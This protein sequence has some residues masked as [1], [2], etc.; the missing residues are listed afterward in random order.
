MATGGFRCDSSVQGSGRRR[1][2]FTQS[3]TGRNRISGNEGFTRAESFTDA[4]TATATCQ[5][6][7]TITESRSRVVFTGRALP[8]R[9]DAVSVLL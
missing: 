7:I 4:E 9:V 6:S 1:V 5:Y 8:V 3:I 2:G